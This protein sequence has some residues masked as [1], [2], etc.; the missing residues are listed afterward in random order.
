MSTVDLPLI[1]LPPRPGYGTAGTRIRLRANHFAI[2]ISR[3]PPLSLYHV[4]VSPPDRCPPRPA[5]TTRAPLPITAN[6]S[7]PP[8]LCR[9]VMRDLASKEKWPAVAYDGASQMFAPVGSVPG[10][11][12]ADGVSFVLARPRDV[13][14]GGKEGDDFTVKVKYAGTIDI[15]A[16]L[17]AHARGDTPGVMP[18]AALQALDAVLR[19]ERA[20]D[21]SWI[22]VGRSFLDGSFRKRI[23]GGYEVWLGHSQSARSTQGGTHLVIDRAAA[24]FVAPMRAIG[25]L[26]VVLDAGGGGGGGRGGGR[27]GGETTSHTLPVAC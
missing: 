1:P 18:A 19:Q 24:A 25:R 8:R 16:S 11:D 12:D 2:D 26:S 14:G 27:G 20:N 15:T 22:V 5:T 13:P 3:V 17:A 7:L 23:S 10:A 21:A 9:A 4:T 6:R